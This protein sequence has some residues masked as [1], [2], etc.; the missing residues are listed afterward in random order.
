MCT[1]VTELFEPCETLPEYRSL[2]FYLF[3]RFYIYFLF[4]DINQVFS[5]LFQLTSCFPYYFHV[6]YQEQLPL[7]VH[8]SELPRKPISFQF[9]WGYLTKLLTL[10]ISC[11]HLIALR[12]CLIALILPSFLAPSALQQS[13]LVTISPSLFFRTALAMLLQF[14]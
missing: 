5:S 3:L 2:V 1:F 11:F 12:V 13:F 7:W 8:L 9:T 10:Q 6:S 14:F 4:I